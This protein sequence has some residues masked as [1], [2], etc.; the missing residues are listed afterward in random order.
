MQTISQIDGLVKSHWGNI[1]TKYG[2]S[3]QYPCFPNDRLKD[4]RD[5]AYLLQCARVC[6]LSTE[7]Q[8]LK[9]FFCQLAGHFSIII[10]EIYPI[11]DQ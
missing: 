1:R 10:E 3:C 4:L 9:D 2:I 6:I 11:E 5:L 8:V 7:N